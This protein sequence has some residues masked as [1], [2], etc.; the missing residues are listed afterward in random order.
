M[1]KLKLWYYRNFKIISSET[2]QCFGLK[3]Y[4]NIHGDSINDYNCR[5]IWKD[6]KENIYRIESL[7]SVEDILGS[8]SADDTNWKLKTEYRKMQKDNA[9]L[10]QVVEQLMK[11]NRSVF[12]NLELN[13]KVRSETCFILGYSDGILEWT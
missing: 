7:I 6:E 3:P 1:R 13:S 5:S 11:Q 8:I 4:R 9:T 10:K 2:A 12:L